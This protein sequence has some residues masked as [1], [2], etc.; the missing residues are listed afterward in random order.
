MAELTEVPRRALSVGEA[1]EALG[2]SWDLWHEYVEPDVRLI[3]LGR[4]KVIPVAELERWLGEH[5][6]RVPKHRHG[7]GGGRG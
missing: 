7:R 3:R 4:R 1:C 5:G 6:E 2:I